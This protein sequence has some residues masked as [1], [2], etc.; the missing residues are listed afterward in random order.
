MRGS[1][2]WVI[3]SFI[4]TPIIEGNW[5]GFGRENFFFVLK[6]KRS[7]VSL[8][9]KPMRPLEHAK[10]RPPLSLW[11][12]LRLVSIP[13]ALLAFLYDSSG[14]TVT[15]LRDY[16]LV[17][18]NSYDTVYYVR[19]VKTGYQGGD[20]TS[21]FSCI[22]WCRCCVQFRATTFRFGSSRLLSVPFSLLFCVA[23]MGS[24]IQQLKA[25]F[26]T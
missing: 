3:D 1:S 16:L 18:W 19:I 24:I 13:I 11:L 7:S 26:T 12:S 15:H 6:V 20:I 25:C 21:G 23:D 8:R 14:R 10:T 9:E 2:W 22:Y 5:L 17:P 4:Q